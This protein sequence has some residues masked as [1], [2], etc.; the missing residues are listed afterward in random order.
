MKFPLFH[1]VYIIPFQSRRRIIVVSLFLNKYL[2][3][4]SVHI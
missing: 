2:Y 3:L 4:Y 1:I